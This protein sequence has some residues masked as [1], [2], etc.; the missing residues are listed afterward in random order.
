MA[1][2]DKKN[3]GPKS[4]DSKRTDE[5]TDANLT[6]AADQDLSDRR[7]NVFG[8]ITSSTGGAN[9]A[10]QHGRDG[11]EI[12]GQTNNPAPSEAA[13]NGETPAAEEGAEEVRNESSTKPV[14][15]L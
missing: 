6:A 11:G 5:V 4:E 13:V 10:G 12:N 8:D 3:A 9:N 2:E 15:T 7:G 1:T 14:K